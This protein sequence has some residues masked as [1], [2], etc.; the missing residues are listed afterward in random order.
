LKSQIWQTWIQQNGFGETGFHEMGFGETG[1][2]ETE[3]TGLGL[4]L[5]GC[6][7]PNAYF[8]K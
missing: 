6:P 4:E 8:D 3:D 7:T 5:Q 2:G 1:F